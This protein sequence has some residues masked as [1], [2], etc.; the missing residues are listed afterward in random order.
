MDSLRE[1]FLIIILHVKGLITQAFI[2]KEKI[3]T[4][5]KSSHPSYFKLVTI[6][7]NKFLKEPLKI[8]DFSQ[9]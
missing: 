8:K 4:F 7:F 2:V 9:L 3:S 5:P 1:H 6:L